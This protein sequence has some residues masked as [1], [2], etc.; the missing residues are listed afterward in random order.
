[1]PGPSPI[2]RQRELGTKLRALRNEHSMTVEE[3]AEQLLCSATK[4]SRLETAARRPS[5]RDVRDLCVLYKV[6]ESTTAEFMSLAREARESAWW[7]RYSDLNLGPLIGLEQEAIAI[8][9]YSIA[10]IPGLLQ[11][12][13][14]AK[15]IIKTVAPRMDPRIVQE[16]AEARQLR[17]QVLEDEDRPR[18]HVVLDEA[19]LHRSV[20][21]PSLMVAQ[22]DKILEMMRSGK[23]L[24]QIIPFSA[25]AYAAM[26]AFFSL[27]EFEEDSNLF[28]MVFI[29]GLADNQYL[30]R[31]D[32]IAR[33]RETVEYLRGRALNTSGSIALMNE[34]RDNYASR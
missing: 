20:G 11:T 25:G 28:P 23:V 32:E 15:G 17:Q 7:E 8:T 33:Y 14:Y 34:M 22:L 10:Y 29:E 27:L 1:M 2:A 3:V 21:G 30:Q 16:R 19:V 26:D 13:D 5:L 9:C 4:I 18:F 6:D 24:A 31:A 12:Q